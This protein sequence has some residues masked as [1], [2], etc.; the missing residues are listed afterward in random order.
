MNLYQKIKKVIISLLALGTFGMF[1]SFPAFASGVPYATGDVFI[2][3][4]AGKIQH[5]NASGVLLDTLDTATGCNEDLGMAFDPSG[6]LF[7]TAAFGSCF[8][9][10]KV[11]KFNNMGNLIG[12]FGSGYSSSTES[13][14]ID[15]SNNVYVGQ[16]DGT[17]ALKKFNSAGTFLADYFPATEDRGTDWNDLSSDQCTMFYTSEGSRVK[18]FNTCTNT[19]L[20]DF[21]TGLAAPCY[22]LRIRSNGEVIVTCQT[23]AYRLSSTG[24]VMQTYPIADGFLFAMNLDPDGTHF[25]TAGYSSHKV[26][27]VDISSGLATT[28]FTAATVGPNLSGLAVFGEPT[29]AKQQITLS[30][31]TAQNPAGTSHTVTA[32][33]TAGGKP[34]SGVTVTFS[35][36]SGPDTGI[37][38]TAVTDAS[39]NASFTYTNP[40]TTG[41]DTIQAC[42]VDKS[43]N[44]QCA[45]A[46]K[47]WVNTQTTTTY[48]GA[49]TQDFNDPAM[50][51]AKLVDSSNK[52]VSGATIVFKI[53]SQTCSSVTDASGN[54]SCTI[55]PNEAAGTYTVTASYAGD[56]SHQPSNASSIFT[57]T[58]EE[59]TTAYTG[60]VNIAQGQPV[61][62]VLK[63]DGSMP[64]GG[65]TISLMLATGENCSGITDAN[66][67]VSCTLS[68]Y[69]LGP[70][71]ITASFAGDT[72]YK[73][74]SDTKPVLIF[75]TL[76]TGSFVLGDQTVNTAPPMTTLTWWGAQWWKLNTLSRGSAPAGFK[77]FADT[78]SSSPTCGKPWSTDPGNS[79]QPPTNVPS[80]MAVIVTDS[81]SKSGNT[82][83]GDTPKIVIVKTEPGYANDPGHAGTGTVVATLCG[84]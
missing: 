37:T 11:V 72:F 43:G 18:K 24:T 4:G 28:V 13:I 50:L 19:Q 64:I 69:P 48:T 56:K 57:V 59:T 15:G 68:G 83:L 71:N 16:P 42:F 6:N 52:P 33:V 27:K 41:T 49:T 66:G 54:A 81:I 22:A 65:R 73:Q 67:V 39:G 32:S 21:A 74:S 34:V 17:K 78:T 84:K 31:A 70:N 82:I 47:E 14:V 25:W 77:G 76:S 2:G 75:A 9:S 40:G 46:T 80:Y 79:S 63:E 38:G 44:K 53:S 1:A 20:S 23:Q 60:P 26:Y 51:S 45:T 36:T 35:I 58:L 10:G 62:A 61:S 7:A 55:T 8:G 30:P 29:V 3:A 12:P 5:Y